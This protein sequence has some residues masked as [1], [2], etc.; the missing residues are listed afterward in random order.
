ML[1]G[2][3]PEVKAG[4]A[5]LAHELHELLRRLEILAGWDRTHRVRREGVT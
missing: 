2:G 4:R 1:E 5:T 3:G